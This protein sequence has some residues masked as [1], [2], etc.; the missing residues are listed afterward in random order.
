MGIFLD[1]YKKKLLSCLVTELLKCLITTAIQQTKV[2]ET[3]ARHA[4]KYEYS[5]TVLL[6]SVTG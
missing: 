2:Q 5:D 1:I 6:K 3:Q 4:T